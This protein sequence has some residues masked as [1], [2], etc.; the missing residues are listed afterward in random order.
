MSKAKICAGVMQRKRLSITGTGA[1]IL[2][3]LHGTL[4]RTVK[5]MTVE[6]G[7]VVAGVVLGLLIAYVI[8]VIAAFIHK[9]EEYDPSWMDY[10]K[11][12]D[13]HD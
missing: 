5:K 13:D 3:G 4:C 2:Y 12:S 10:K 1:R 9:P 11:W 6:I 7:L 8:A